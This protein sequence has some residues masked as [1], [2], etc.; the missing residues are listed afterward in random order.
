MIGNLTHVE[1]RLRE[2]GLL[3]TAKELVTLAKT[4]SESENSALILGKT[5]F[6]SII[7]ICRNGFP[8][9]IFERFENE[10]NKTSLRVESIVDLTQ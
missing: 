10:V 1:K 5:N 4:F 7:L 9:T 8:I 3:F 2:R 6:L